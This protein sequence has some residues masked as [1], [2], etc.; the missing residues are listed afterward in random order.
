MGPYFSMK[1][2]FNILPVSLKKF[3]HQFEDLTSILIIQDIFLSTL[4]FII[5]A[6]FDNFLIIL[7]V[8]RIIHHTISSSLK[9]SSHS[10]MILG[11]FI[12]NS[13]YTILYVWFL[14][15]ITIIIIHLEHSCKDFISIWCIL[16][17]FYVIWV[18]SK[19]DCV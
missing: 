14:L 18:I 16:I 4:Y 6:Y 17:S 12:I 10:S 1:T 9:I 8:W 3:E 5:W 15:W 7:R 13:C 11:I 19:L 2:Y